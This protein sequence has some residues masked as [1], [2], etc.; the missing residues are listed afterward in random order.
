MAA[1]LLKLSYKSGRSPAINALE[2]FLHTE[3]G[4]CKVM[5][6]SEGGNTSTLG[7]ETKAKD[8]GKKG[9]AR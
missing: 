5:D 6:A 3:L 1:N 2:S 9:K 8:V 7:I 4:A